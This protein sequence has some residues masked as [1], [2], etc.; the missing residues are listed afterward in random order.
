MTNT[1]ASVDE[2]VAQPALALVGAS[3]S[4]H[5][6]GNAILRELRAKGMHVYPVHPVADEIDGV[7]C[8]RHFADLPEPVG[9]VIVS[10]APAEAISVVRDA[11]EAGITRVWLQQ[12][13]ESPYAEEVCSALGVRAVMGECILMHASPTGVHKVHRVIDGMLGKLPR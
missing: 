5:K 4:G 10:V 3:R 7:P 13:A 9:G 11:S 8:Y 2:F 6:F 1:R 12:G